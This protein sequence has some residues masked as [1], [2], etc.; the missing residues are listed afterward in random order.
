MELHEKPYLT[1]RKLFENQSLTSATH[2]DKT[3]ANID[4]LVGQRKEIIMT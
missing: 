4:Q 1:Y 3:L 2:K